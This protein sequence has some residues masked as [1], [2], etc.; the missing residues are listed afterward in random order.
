MARASE[1][2]PTCSLDS[3]V[4]AGPGPQ[5]FGASLSWALV[6]GGLN[7]PW[8]LGQEGWGVRQSDPLGPSPA[9]SCS[10]PLATAAGRLP[11]YPLG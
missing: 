8:S 1:G 3:G 7:T 4:G 6:K 9:S 11:M 2:M 10:V 5:H